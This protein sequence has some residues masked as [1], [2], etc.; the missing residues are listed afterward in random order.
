MI[1]IRKIKTRTKNIKK[2]NK[3]NPPMITAIKIII[4]KRIIMKKIRI[5]SARRKKRK[6]RKRRKRVNPKLT[7]ILAKISLILILRILKS[8]VKKILRKFS[9]NLILISNILIALDKT[10]I[11]IPKGML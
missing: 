2:K 5:K 9:V 6:N 10:N 7:R 3:I 1:K 11:L 8:N 4:I